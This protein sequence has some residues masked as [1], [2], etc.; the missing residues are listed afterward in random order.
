VLLSTVKSFC[1]ILKMSVV[2]TN[3]F[4]AVCLQIIETIMGE[5]F[6]FAKN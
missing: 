1:N 3:I 4:I 5:S 2:L 6:I